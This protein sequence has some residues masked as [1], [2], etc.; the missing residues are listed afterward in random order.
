MIVDMSTVVSLAS[1]FFDIERSSNIAGRRLLFIYLPLPRVR[2]NVC[3]EWVRMTL[4]SQSQPQFDADGS[5]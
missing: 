2:V 4:G 5:F 1:M 3:I